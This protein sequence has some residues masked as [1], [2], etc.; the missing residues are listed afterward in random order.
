MSYHENCERPETKPVAD[1]GS[2]ANGLEAFIHSLSIRV[3]YYRSF[4]YCLKWKGPMYLRR[5]SRLPQA[6]K[7]SPQRSPSPHEEVIQRKLRGKRRGT[8]QR[9]TEADEGVVN[10]DKKSKRD[11][12]DIINDTRDASVA[13]KDEGKFVEIADKGVD[14]SDDDCCSVNSSIASGPSLLPHTS[15]Q[16]PAQGL[17]SACHKLY[18]RAKKMKAPIKNKLLNNDP[19][20]LTCD[21]WVLIKKWMPRRLPNA[22]GKLLIHVQRVT[23]KLRVKKRLKQHVGE[24]SACSRPH[25]FLQRN[26]RCCVRAT[27]KNDRK[28]KTRRKRTRD[29][30]QGS[31]VAKQQRRRSNRHRQH[32]GDD[33]GPLPTS[34]PVALE[35]TKPRELKP[36]PKTTKKTSGFRDLLA[37]LRGNSSI[38]VR[39][40][41]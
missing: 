29:D 5:S 37:Q 17:C 16:R 31:R 30:S 40:T 33:S 6:S 41:R 18:Q 2:E 21:Q 15:K 32:T 9:K 25:T 7:K 26:L 28:K 39:E 22:R 10:T 36:M 1:I 27:V 34:S 23:K 4:E 35:T 8:W 14:E 38:I 12:I 20:S 19:K 13:E 11:I 24:S 3:E